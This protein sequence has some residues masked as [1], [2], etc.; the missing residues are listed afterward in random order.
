MASVSAESF[1]LQQPVHQSYQNT[2]EEIAESQNF[3]ATQENNESEEP[4]IDIAINNVVSTFST[5][6]HLNL[7]KVALEGVNV[8]YRRE[9][10]V[11]LIIF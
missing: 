9:N 5:R 11:K 6:C 8:V 10:G 4:S 1:G 2:P 3:V 7:K